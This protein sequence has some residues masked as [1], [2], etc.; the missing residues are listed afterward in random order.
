M[1]QWRHKERGRKRLTRNVAQNRSRCPSVRLLK[2]MHDE[3]TTHYID[4][5]DQTALGHQFIQQEFGVFPSVGWQIG[6]PEQKRAFSF[7]R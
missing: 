5:L 7:P 6:Q 1:G 3:A 2:V 4:C